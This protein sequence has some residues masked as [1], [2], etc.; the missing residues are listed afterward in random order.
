MTS[1]IPIQK[2]LLYSGA[3]Y[4]VGKF[5]ETSDTTVDSAFV[6]TLTT[7][8]NIFTSARNILNESSNN[9]TST[10]STNDTTTQQLRQLTEAVAKLSQSNNT[11]PNTVVIRS[12]QEAAS[13]SALGK[14]LKRRRASI[15][16]ME[17]TVD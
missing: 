13:S 14:Y 4:G 9:T 16:Y 7:C 15:A 8:L 2:I 1:K 3:G 11:T 12:T 17:S 6:S 5:I 10:P